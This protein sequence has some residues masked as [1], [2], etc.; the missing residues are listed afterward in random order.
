MMGYS[1]P[2]FAVSR[3]WFQEAGINRCSEL[4]VRESWRVTICSF[5]AA[6]IYL[7]PNESKSV[8]PQLIEGLHCRL[9]SHRQNDAELCL[10]AQ[11]TFI[12]LC[13]F[14]E[15]IGLNHR[16][17]AGQLGET[18]SVILIRRRTRS[19]ALN[20]SAASNELY[21]CNFNGIESRTDHHE[22]PIRSQ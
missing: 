16:A 2:S 11:H 4:A 14:F 7:S 21:R 10:A 8:F 19:P 17:H 9:T 18:Q 20:G 13:C 12:T 15:W 22:L 5:A 6:F 3:F 1:I